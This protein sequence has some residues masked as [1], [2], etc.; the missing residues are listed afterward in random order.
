VLHTKGKRGLLIWNNGLKIKVIN[1]V[2]LQEKPTSYLFGAGVWNFFGSFN[3][4]CIVMA[5]GSSLPKQI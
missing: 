5:V 1:R 4:P 3:F 2:L